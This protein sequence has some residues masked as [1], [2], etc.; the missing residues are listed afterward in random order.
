MTKTKI[1]GWAKATGPRPA[2]VRKLCQITTPSSVLRGLSLLRTNA[3][4]L[5][6][7]PGSLTRSRDGALSDLHVR[8]FV[9]QGV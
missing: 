7:V 4:I 1:Q 3:Q 2:L 6:A 8:D 9:A 5:S